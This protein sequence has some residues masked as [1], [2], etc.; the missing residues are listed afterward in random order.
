MHTSHI[1]LQM[2]IFWLQAYQ[3]GATRTFMTE[4]KDT[5]IIPD[6]YTVGQVAEA[7]SVLRS[8]IDQSGGKSLP[9]GPDDQGDCHH[10]YC[11]LQQMQA[12]VYTWD[13]Q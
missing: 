10:M 13:G 1:H 5:Y 9:G 11:N 3:A 4:F 6:F 12:Q 8:T 7:V 2:A